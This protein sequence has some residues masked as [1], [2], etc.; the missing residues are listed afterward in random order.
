MKPIRRPKDLIPIKEV[1]LDDISLLL[2]EFWGDGFLEEII[3]DPSKLIGPLL[4]EK[5]EGDQLWYC[6]T[7]IGPLCGHRGIALMR[8]G[9]PLL[10]IKFMQH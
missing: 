6:S 10:Y 8:K 7:R 9:V 2:I 3:F 1:T 4:R 5:E